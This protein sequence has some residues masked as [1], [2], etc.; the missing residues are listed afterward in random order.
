MIPVKDNQGTIAS[1]YSESND[2][3]GCLQKKTLLMIIHSDLF[4]FS[5]FPYQFQVYIT[6]TS[7]V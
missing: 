1:N 3:E 5:G 4:Y 7:E 6:S 2:A